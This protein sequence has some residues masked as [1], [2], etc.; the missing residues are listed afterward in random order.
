MNLTYPPVPFNRSGL[1][2]IAEFD[3]VSRA[4]R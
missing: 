2:V 3:D 1:P 4:C